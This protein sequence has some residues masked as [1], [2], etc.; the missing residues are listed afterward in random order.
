[1]VIKIARHLSA[2]SEFLVV[3][4][5]VGHVKH[6]QSQVSVQFLAAL[7]LAVLQVTALY[8]KEVSA[9]RLVN[10]TLVKLATAQ[11]VFMSLEVFA[12]QVH[13][14]KLVSVHTARQIHPILSIV[15]TQ[16]ETRVVQT[17][18]AFQVCVLH[19][20]HPRI[21]IAYLSALA[22]PAQTLMCVTHQA[23]NN[24]PMEFVSGFLTEIVAPAT[25]SV[26]T[27]TA[28]KVLAKW[29]VLVTILQHLVESSLVELFSLA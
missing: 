29:R 9:H 15:I 3:L 14:V 16:M 12:P 6:V 18:H 4:P 2:T 7:L 19:Q 26:L 27:I 24:V 21:Y 1:M 23:T 10:A 13:N 28:T 22:R 25:T 11:S 5:A 8:P 17:L 20:V